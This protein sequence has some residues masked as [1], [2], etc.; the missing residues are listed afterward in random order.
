MN[1]FHESI[2][3]EFEKEWDNAVI[4]DVF[5]AK[6]YRDNVRLLIL[7]ALSR[8]EAAKEQEVAKAIHWT[9]HRKDYSVGDN[10]LAKENKSGW[11]SAIQHINDVLS[12]LDER[13]G[14]V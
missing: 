13:K 4:D 1:P 11:N 9:K 3:K 2:L 5:S 10:Q 14:K 6:L 7:S 12:S 8:V